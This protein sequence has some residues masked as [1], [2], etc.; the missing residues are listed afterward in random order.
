MTHDPSRQSATADQYVQR[1]RDINETYTD[2]AAARL[3]QFDGDA[4]K[5]GAA[6]SIQLME[7]HHVQPGQGQQQLAHLLS[8]L[9][10]E[11]A[12]ARMKDDGEGER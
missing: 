1:L 8:V 2:M 10:V 4:T 7:H 9:Y 6:L 5:A 3:E 12:Q 11:R